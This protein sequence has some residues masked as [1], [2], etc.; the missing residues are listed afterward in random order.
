[1]N[2]RALAEFA[3][4]GFINMMAFRLRYYTGI[5]TYFINVTVYYFIWKA[6]FEADPEFSS[7]RFEEML[8]YVSIGW[9]MRSVYFNNIDV[10]LSQEIIEGKITSALLKPIDLQAS[11][12]ARAAGEALFRLLMLAVPAGVLL[13]AVYPLLPP[14]GPQAFLLFA[15][16]MLGSVLLVAAINFIVG[17]FAVKMKSI[18]GLLRAKFYLM[19]LLSGLIVPMTLFPAPLREVSGWLPFEHIGYTP[20][21]I[22]LGKSS[23]A[24]AWI[25]LG[26]TYLWVFLLL[27][28]GWWFWRWMMR[29]ITI[30]GG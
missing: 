24:A 6:V 25:A 27:A 9:V 22:Y 10:Q 7:L 16:A 20:M 11:I 12:V 17:A 5:I 1:M 14:A 30:H 21:M 4:I 3:K 29:G 2:L 28:G 18:L 23:G 13:F 19:D 15:V 26:V 8:T